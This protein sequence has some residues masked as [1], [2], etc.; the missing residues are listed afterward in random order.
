MSDNLEKFVKQ[1]RAAFDSELPSARVWQQ[2]EK[3]TLPDKKIRKLININ[4]KFVWAAAVVALLAVATIIYQATEI[5][6]LKSNQVAVEMPETNQLPPELVDLDKIY[7]AQVSHTFKQLNDFPEEA[8]ELR[9]ELLELDVEF[10]ELQQEL[11][12]EVGR[13]EVLRAMIENYRIKLDL[14]EGT[15]EH[16]KRSEKI[17]E[18]EDNIEL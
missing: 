12:A 2:I 18:D 8:G 10:D 5:S 3:N 9:E 6:S 16:F 14:L 11:G 17:I 15:L 7:V 13:E 4:R 1:N